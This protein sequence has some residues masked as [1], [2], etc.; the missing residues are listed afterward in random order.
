MQINQ[1]QN[2]I[3][4]QFLHV[5]EI[6]NNNKEDDYFFSC[7]SLKQLLSLRMICKRIDFFVIASLELAIRLGSFD[8]K[9]RFSYW[10]HK[11]RVIEL[12]N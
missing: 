11:C 9:Y 5:I 8:D 3:D 4:C 1:I 2:K 7:F 6:L 10:I 12:N